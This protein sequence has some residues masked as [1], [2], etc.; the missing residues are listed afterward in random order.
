[1]FCSKAVLDTDEEPDFGPPDDSKPVPTSVRQHA[2]MMMQRLQVTTVLRK[3][4]GA[5][6][7]DV[8]PPSPLTPV[9]ATKSD[10]DTTAAA[11]A[12][13]AGMGGGGGGSG[14]AAAMPPEVARARRRG[15]DVEGR[16]QQ[17]RKFVW[18]LYLYTKGRSPST[19]SDLVLSYALLLCIINFAYQNARQD[20]S[21]VNPEYEKDANTLRVLCKKHAV[22]SASSSSSDSS[23]CGKGGAA[24]AAGKSPT[25]PVA[26]A[27]ARSLGVDAKTF[28]LLKDVSVLNERIWKP[29]LI[30]HASAGVMLELT[31][32]LLGAFMFTG[33]DDNRRTLFEYAPRDPRTPLDRNLSNVG[34]AYDTLILEQGMVDERGPAAASREPAMNGAMLLASLSTPGVP[35]S[36]AA[37][38]SPSA[39]ASPYSLAVP[40]SPSVARSPVSKAL[41]SISLL[42]SLV[43]AGTR[44]EAGIAA[45]PPTLV[46]LV[47][48][49]LQHGGDGV[50]PPAGATA[51]GGGDWRAVVSN[52]VVAVGEKFDAALAKL[53]STD[54]GEVVSA[55]RFDVAAGFYYKALESIIEQEIQPRPRHKGLVGLLHNALFNESLLACSIQ[56]TLYAYRADTTRLAF[57]WV[58]QAVGGLCPFEFQKVVEILVRSESGYGT[59]P[60][61]FRSLEDP[62]GEPQMP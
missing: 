53:G 42:Q 4:F 47:T 21:H 1:M 38:S 13:M 37:A 34:R 3:K 15:T 54:G 22:A 58:L 8:F 43:G 35:Y 52:R 30:K 36:R 29:F 5:I 20:P 41:T 32:D 31:Q 27:D 59:I 25:T 18:T 10:A 39:S 6:F 60:P 33:D 12:A 17:I 51:D 28:D 62:D 9:A 44:P 16:R 46:A 14:A 2:S 19:S 23:S 45:V 55:G 48:R 61:A 57:P 49:L 7:D 40:G 56:I 50:P 24:A 26:A 11:M